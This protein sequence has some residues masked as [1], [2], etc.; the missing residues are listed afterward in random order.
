[1]TPPAPAR[2]IAA[3]ESTFARRV[4]AAKVPVAVVFRAPG[5]EASRA[6]VLCLARLAEQYAGRLVVLSVDIDRAPLLAQQYGVAVSPTLLVLEYGDELTR[7]V[8]FAPERLLR[9]L[10]DQ[11][12]AGELLPGLLWSPTEQDFEDAVIIPLLDAWGWSYR[13]QVS[14]KVQKGKT[15]SHGRIDILAYADDASRPLTLFEA[16]RQ[17]VHKAALQQAMTQAQGYAQAL[18]LAM[19]V[20]AAPV[21]LWIYGLN[22]GKARLVEMFSSLDVAA[23]PDIVKRTLQW[24]DEAR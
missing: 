21:G 11:V 12:L 20:V 10:F 23:R 22:T 17:I 7:M 14:C 6:L 8:G 24:I 18:D 3:N 2:L 9:L 15:T 5:C 4:R 19:F 1:M 13:R 16:K